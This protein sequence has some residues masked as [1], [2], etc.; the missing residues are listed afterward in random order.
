MPSNDEVPPSST[1]APVISECIKKL[2]QEYV[3]MPFLNLREANHQAELWA[4]LRQRLA[5]PK[6]RARIEPKRSRQPHVHEEVLI[7]R[8]QLELKVGNTERTDIIVFGTDRL[9]TLTCDP[10]GPVAV[11]LN[12]CPDDVEAAIEIKCAPS[13]KPDCRRSIV[14]DVMKLHEL[15][16]RAPHIRCFFVLLDMSL[17][18]PGATS[19]E[20]TDESWRS[21]LHERGFVNSFSPSLAFVEAWDLKSGNLPI[22][23]VEY[24]SNGRPNTYM[25]PP[26]KSA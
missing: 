23:R 22:P 8:V 11:L 14:E 1:L 9:V 15:Q 19:S 25:A 16:T 13:R 6:V 20:P 10:A 24:W 4:M 2:L 21:E 18:V 3:S 7:S 5:P 26:V 17:S 12:V